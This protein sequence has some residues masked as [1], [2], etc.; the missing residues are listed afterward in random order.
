M[1]IAANQ[2]VQSYTLLTASPY[3]ECRSPTAKCQA[4]RDLGT[5]LITPWMGWL[6]RKA[7]CERG[8]LHKARKQWTK[9]KLGWDFSIYHPTHK[10]LNHLHCRKPASE[11][12]CPRRF[13]RR[14]HCSRL[15]VVP[16]SLS[17][18]CVT[19]KKTARNNGRVKTWGRD[20]D[21]TCREREV[22]LF[23]RQARSDKTKKD[24]Q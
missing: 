5:R 9:R 21:Y 3:L 23:L 18:S 14:P 16:L 20:T 11:L 1:L 4:E 13:A 7:L 22:P 24:K 19:R 8:A 12:S 6:W 17:T 10:I 2:F 15:R